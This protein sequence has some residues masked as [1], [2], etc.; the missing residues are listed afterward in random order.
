MIPIV[1]LLI[2]GITPRSYSQAGSNTIKNVSAKLLQDTL[3]NNYE[4]VYLQFDKPYYAVG[5]TIYFKGYITLGAQHKLS[6]LSGVLNVDL[7]SPDNNIAERLKLPII[8]GTA[9]GDFALPD[10]LKG[11]SYRVS[12]YTNWMRNESEDS[13][14]EQTLLVG[15]PKGSDIS[16]SGDF[17]RKKSTTK[18]PAQK[19]DV[20]F[21]P[22][23]GSLV[24]G[25]YSKIAFKATAPNGRGT[26]VK[27]TVTDEGGTVVCTFASAHLGMGAF[28]FVPEAGKTYRANL[29]YADGTANTIE[30]PKA[31]P[32]GYTINLNNTNP[33]TV[34]LRITAG[35]GSSLDN[36]SIVARAG[37]RI[38]HAAENQ[39]PGSKF[40]SAVIPKNKF[41]TGIVQFT[42]FSPSGEPLNERLAFINNNDQLKVYL[43]AKQSY[44]PRQI[45]QIVLIAKDKDHRPAT[46]S[47]SVA[48]T[49]ETKVQ[50]DTV[51]ENTI[52]SELLLISDLK[53]T[54]EEPNYYFTNVNAKT[55]ADLDN[56][57]LTQ[58]YRHFEW[59]RILS[60]SP[61]AIAYRP[62]KGLT[63]A[64][65][66]KKNSK[67]VANAK[68]MLF[69]KSGGGFM[70]DTLTD[71]NG[72]FIFENLVFADSTKFVVQ[73]KVPKGQDALTLELDTIFPPHEMERNNDNVTTISN[74]DLSAYLV[75]QQQFFREQ[76]QYGINKHAVVLKEVVVKAKK[77]FVKHS[78]NL[79][80]AGNADEVVTADELENSVG[81]TLSFR[82]S[83]KLFSR[84]KFVQGVPY[85]KCG[86]D[87]ASAPMQIVIDGNYVDYD[88]Y[89]K[90]DP[91][92]V[93]SVEVLASP[94]FA[95]V[96]G[97][98]GG[99]GILVITT[100]RYED[101]KN[102]Y[103]R[104]A[105]G[106][107]TYVPKGFY[108]AREFYS[109]QYDN[110]GTNPKMNDLRS[111]IYWQPNI[112][113]DKD[114]KAAFSYFNADKKGIYRVVIEG[115]DTDGNLGRLVYRYR[116]E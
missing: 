36:V 92:R 49:D 81:A 4:K 109:P 53:G 24:A 63:I 110:P 65:T 25:N 71:A 91:D 76:Q 6:A 15:A 66:V 21:M 68:V 106:V 55:E 38:W 8:A 78:D 47:F 88:E 29:V 45:V 20:Q 86:I 115:I 79:N 32:Q 105:P 99:H 58:G 57:M 9:S 73:A 113:T 83:S 54:V 31:A 26:D 75:N 37:G 85:C 112:I 60:S 108:K 30:L 101:Y 16:E 103:K 90:L 48:V 13:F 33:D 116:V 93:Q 84:V 98:R 74:A 102:S 17:T 64:G 59:K 97:P 46:G 44:T 96:Y 70:M 14:F 94:N 61:P 72:R 7:V 69:S 100:K 56:L 22:E 80:G 111:T 89:D 87:P 27:G 10:T 104:Y 42:L 95:T 77:N 52:L 67:L 35:G 28:S 1:F 107:V 3:S 62:E 50:P 41:P 82:L 34:R 40:F 11:G 19:T 12:A 23:G 51:N 18:G 2:V 39:H 43:T 114:G 5:D